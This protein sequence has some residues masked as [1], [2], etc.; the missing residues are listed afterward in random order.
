L[1]AA[2]SVPGAT[3]Y[4]A[5]PPGTPLPKFIA[6][7]GSS[8]FTY[9]HSLAWVKNNFVLGRCDYHYKHEVIL[10]GW[11]PDA[12]HLWNGD[13]S[14]DSVFVVD[15]PHKSDL[16]PTM[17]PPELIAPMVTNSSRQGEIVFDPFVG[18]GSTAIAAAQTGR[19]CYCCDVASQYVDVTVRRLAEALKLPA[20]LEA[21]GTQFPMEAT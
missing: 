15:K 17:K 18:S 4:A 11:K 6:A 13:H 14:Q 3:C 8:G 19:V 7:F 16:H 1:A 20:T 21:D 9:R 5:C 2:F 10:Y 12:G